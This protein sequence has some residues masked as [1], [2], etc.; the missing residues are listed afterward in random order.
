MLKEKT[1]LFKFIIT[2]DRLLNV[3][4][5]GSLQECLSTRAYVKAKTNSKMWIK[6][7]K[8]ID[9]IFTKGHCKESFKWEYQI[10]QDYVNRN[11]R[12]MNIF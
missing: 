9:T 11:K 5:G 12:L 4:T 2:L 1:F 3:C 6:I 8:F 10:K 7:E